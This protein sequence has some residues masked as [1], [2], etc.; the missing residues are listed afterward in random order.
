MKTLGLIGGM[1]WESTATYYRLLN[2]HAKAALGGLHSARLVLV[3]V[4]FAEVEALQA[5]GDW[6]AAGA[7]LA[8]ACRQPGFVVVL[9]QLPEKGVEVKP[10]RTIYVTI[11][12]FSQKRVPVPYVAGRSL[13]QAKNMLEIAGLEIAE[14]VY[15][16]D[17]ATNYVL[18]EADL[19]IC[20]VGILLIF[21]AVLIFLEARRQRADPFQQD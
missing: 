8:R 5:C 1:S 11:N 16:P 12:S 17:M 4:D 14:L 6:D 9:D 19:L 2:E 20:A 21:A 13:R 3:S 15:R 18:E 10:G 7:L